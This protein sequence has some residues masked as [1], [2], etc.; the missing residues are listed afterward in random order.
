MVY[1][2]YAI[3]GARR[4]GLAFVVSSINPIV[5]RKTDTDSIIVLNLQFAHF[6]FIHGQGC[7]IISKL[8]SLDTFDL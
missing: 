6:V 3:L 2:Q 7:E 4:L 1:D 5:V 8:K